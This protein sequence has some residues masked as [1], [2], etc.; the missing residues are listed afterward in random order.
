VFKP[1]PAFMPPVHRPSVFIYELPTDLVDISEH[2][3]GY[4]YNFPIYRAAEAFLDYLYADWSVRTENPHEA[5]LFFIPALNY[6][7]SG[8]TGFPSVHAAAVIQHVR[9]HYPFWNRTNGRDHFMMFTN[10][11]GSCH[12]YSQDGEFGDFMR[13]VHFA[14]H[15]TNSVMFKEFPNTDYAC[16]K[17][18]RDVAFPPFL[19]FSAQ[20]QVELTNWSAGEPKIHAYL[21]FFAGDIRQSDQ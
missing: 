4:Q 20:A 21:L 15:E 17:P 5:N 12:L 19:N 10:D 7:F 2:Y 11:R 6:D 14:Y 18:L 13:L 9:E 3:F 1:S 8:N 16:F